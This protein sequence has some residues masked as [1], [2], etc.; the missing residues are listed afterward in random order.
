MTRAPTPA[1][2][3]RI[4]AGYSLEAVARDLIDEI[5]RQRETELR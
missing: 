4:A 1:E 3:A 5:D 2:A